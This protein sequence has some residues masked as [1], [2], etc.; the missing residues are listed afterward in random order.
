M[1]L[2]S[3]FFELVMEISPN[4]GLFTAEPLFSSLAGEN[5]GGSGGGGILLEGGV[6]GGGGGGGGGGMLLEG[7]VA[8]GGG[9]GMVL[10]SD[11]S[12]S[13][14]LVGKSF[15]GGGTEKRPSELESSKPGLRNS[16]S[17]C[18]F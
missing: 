18:K 17:C 10:A 14:D 1:S 16:D 11:G 3:V 6:A 5:F 8:G 4:P 2:F 12:I 13:P 7:G 9:G 15:F